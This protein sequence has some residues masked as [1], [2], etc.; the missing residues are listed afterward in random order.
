MSSSVNS[1]STVSNLTAVT[2]RQPTSHQDGS[3][4]NVVVA[5]AILFVVIAAVLGF[6]FFTKS[7]P[8]TAPPTAAPAAPAQ[9]AATE[10]KAS[11]DAGALADART[12]AVADHAVVVSALARCGDTNDTCFDYYDP[13]GG[14]CYDSVESK[15]CY[16]RGYTIPT[17]HAWG[18]HPAYD[19]IYK[20]PDKKT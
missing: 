4:K 1:A 20:R 11:A 15:T 8:E 17:G 9:T 18:I 5:T 7:A 16:A 13:P 12:A 10:A 6:Y 2:T 19:L 3:N 14:P